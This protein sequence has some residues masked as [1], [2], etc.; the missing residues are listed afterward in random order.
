M[1]PPLTLTQILNV[2]SS[3]A[4]MLALI[5]VKSITPLCVVYYWSLKY[6]SFRCS[7]VTNTRFQEVKYPALDGFFSNQPCSDLSSKWTISGGNS[8]SY[9][10]GFLGF[11][12]II[13][14]RFTGVSFCSSYDSFI[15][16]LSNANGQSF[17][18]ISTKWN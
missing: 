2:L 8:T 13:V 6:L 5:L 12:R 11:L 18:F 16:S 17:A 10:F 1:S 4:Y 3:I 9:A 14:L 7:T 15:T